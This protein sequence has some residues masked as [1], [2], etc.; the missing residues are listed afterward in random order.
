MRRTFLFVTSFFIFLLGLTS[1]HQSEVRADETSFRVS[2]DTLLTL[3][4]KDKP[5]KLEENQDHTSMAVAINHKGKRFVWSEFFGPSKNY[6]AIHRLQFSPDGKRLAF[7]AEKGSHFFVVVDNQE[8][9]PFNTLVSDSVIFTDDSRRFAFLAGEKPDP[10]VENFFAIVDGEKQGE[11]KGIVHQEPMF[12]PD[13]TDLFYLISENNLHYPVINGRQGRGFPITGV[14]PVYSRAYS[15]FAFM[16]ALNDTAYLILNDSVGSGYYDLTEIDA[17]SSTD[18]FAYSVKYSENGG[19]MV[20]LNGEKQDQYSASNFPRFSPD[21]T[22][23]GYWASDGQNQFA[24]VDSVADSGFD[25]ISDVRFSPKGRHYYY[26]AF[27]Q[28]SPRRWSFV[29]DGQQMPV[30]VGSLTNPSIFFSPDESRWAI[31][32]DAAKGYERAIVDGTEIGEFSMVGRIAFDSTGQHVAFIASKNSGKKWLIYEDGIEHELQKNAIAGPDVAYSPD[33]RHL[34]Y[35]TTDDKGRSLMIDHVS[36]GEWHNTLPLAIS[37][38]ENGSIVFY[39]IDNKHIG[40]VTVE[41][42]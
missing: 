41:W 39:S 22:R 26:M 21:G 34:L 37:F 16:G 30:M 12:S 28:R 17:S 33:G 5:F 38:A 6:D 10:A 40:R 7:T 11:Y 13:G 29:V 31:A 4:K 1:P 18:D 35:W 8:F 2:E 19:S 14:G 24:V 36:V 25:G 27:L 15:A 23:F 20:I 3:E 42:D 32:Y 9:G